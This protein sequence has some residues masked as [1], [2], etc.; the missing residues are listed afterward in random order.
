MDNAFD[1]LDDFADGFDDL[2]D[3]DEN[4]D[5]LLAE[6]D[7]LLED[8]VQNI[9]SSRQTSENITQILEKIGET[10]QKAEGDRQ[11]TQMTTT[12]VIS[13]KKQKAITGYAGLQ[14]FFECK[15]QKSTEPETQQV[16]NLRN[17][18]D[19]VQKQPPCFCCQHTSSARI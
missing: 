7:K 2:N 10:N 6:S 4:D 19:F 9:K 12:S 11:G 13:L 3:S 18:M 17:A 16:N 15:Q 5:E 1:D 8:T 14:N